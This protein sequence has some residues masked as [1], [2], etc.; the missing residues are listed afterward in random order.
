[1]TT[2][3]LLDS[4]GP[5]PKK[6]LTVIKA[7]IEEFT[8]HSREYHNPHDD[9]TRSKGSK[10]GEN[11]NRAAVLEKLK[12]MDRKMPNMDQSIHEILVVCENFNA[13]HL[14]KDYELDVNSNRTDQ[15]C[16]SSGDKYDDDWRKPKK[17]WFPYD[18]YKKQKEEKHRQIGLVVYQKKN[19]HH[20]R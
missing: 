20:P 11:E 4:Q 3:Q 5:M 18:E 16:Y 10:D 1:M 14:T 12:N 9:T 6:E 13:P 8:K 2:R 19:N 15:V 17:E 7:L